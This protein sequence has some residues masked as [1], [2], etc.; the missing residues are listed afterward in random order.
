MKIAQ[1]C[2]P[3]FSVPP[4]GYGGIEWIVALLADG[5]TERGHDVTLFASGGSTTKA[6]LISEFDE[7]PGG[8]KLGQV[9]YEVIHAVSTYRYADEFDIIH[10][11]SGMIGPPIGANIAKPLVHTLHG[12]F[13]EAAK[14]MYSLLAP[15]PGAPGLNV[16]NPLNLVAIS[17]A[18]RAF[19]PDLNYA[20]TVYNGIDTSLYPF[21]E[22][23]ED[24]LLFLGRVNKEKGPEIAVDIAAKAGMKLKMAVKMSEEFEQEYWRDVVHSHLT[25]N[26]EIIGEIS[27]QEKAEL[28]AGAKATLFPI[29]WPE[30]FGLVMTE[31]MAC[32]TPV[33][34]CP[35]GAAPEVI[36]HGETGFL[37]EDP[38]DLVKAI[39]KLDEIDPK[40]CRDHVE[41]TFGK[42]TMVEGY[43]RVFENILNR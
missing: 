9:W 20:G 14:R 30:P 16:K 7:P 4:A 11:H 25:G 10:D 8:T 41:A 22:E 43:E 26:E 18:Q 23:K 33:L 29:Q 15:P 27:V 1:I 28:I 17:E 32:G 12:P 13:T 21:R 40:V 36:R 2:P 6:K 3:W 39:D 31:S 37:H 35:Y 34:A 38:M 5:L 24:Y 42:M 19:C